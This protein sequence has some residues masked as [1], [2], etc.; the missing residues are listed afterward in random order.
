[1][2][3]IR[4]FLVAFL[5]TGA[6]LNTN[7]QA[8]GYMGKHFIVCYDIYTIP[9]LRNYNENGKTGL[10]ALNTRHVISADWVMGLKQ[11]IGL[12]FH[13]TKSQFKFRKSFDFRYKYLDDHG[14]TNYFTS[15][16]EYGDTRGE[17]SAVALGIHTNLYFK[18]FLAP[19]GG[20]FKPE[21]LL[22]RFTASFDDSLA[23]RNLSKNTEN[24]GLHSML[25]YPELTNENAYYTASIGATIGTHYIFYNRIVFDIGFQLG[26]V[27]GSKLFGDY[28]Q[29]DYISSCAKSRLMSQYFLNINA[30]LGIL[31][32]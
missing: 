2:R 11:S 19:L 17:L 1:M 27:F 12:S 31:I 23:N 21:I 4:T 18:K 25:N 10:L 28:N 24:K 26:Y 29:T 8:P 16:M 20:Y 13:Y 9:A 15:S 3:F 32:F 5:F 30:G 22:I 7:A 6:V 14:D